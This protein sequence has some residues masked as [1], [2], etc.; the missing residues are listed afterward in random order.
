[1][2]LGYALLRHGESLH[3]SDPQRAKAVLAEAID[4]LTTAHESLLAFGPACAADAHWCVEQ[5]D[6]AERLRATVGG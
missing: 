3:D 5:K 1:M 4:D 6:F 2:K